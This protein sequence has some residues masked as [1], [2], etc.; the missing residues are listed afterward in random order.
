VRPAPRGSAE[1][2][3]TP[4]TVGPARPSGHPIAARSP[5]AGE[6]TGR[7]GQAVVPTDAHP[8]GHGMAM[9]GMCTV[10]TV[11]TTG[12]GTTG[13]GAIGTTETGAIRT[14]AA[15]AAATGVTAG[16]GLTPAR[17]AD[18][19]TGRFGSAARAG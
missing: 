7:L 9:A 8:S 3:V 13:M 6:A 12:A 16:G 15:G 5:N 11:T 2:G 17:A 1:A 4:E 18:S 19:A 14:G 10:G